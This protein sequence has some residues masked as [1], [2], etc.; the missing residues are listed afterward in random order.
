MAQDVVIETLDTL[1]ALLQK[2]GGVLLPAHRGEAERIV[3]AAWG[4]ERAYIGKL[5]ESGQA[6]ISARD[7]A[8][9]RDF[10]RGTHVEL[11]TRRYGLSKRRIWAILQPERESAAP[12]E[13]TAQAI[14]AAPTAAACL[15]G[16]S[17]GG[18]AAHQRPPARANTTK[19]RAPTT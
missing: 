18:D 15:T 12:A 10:Q 19:A 6:E 3:R 1:I 7:R 14:L 17:A 8:I 5:G 2:N 11:L 9:R 13:Q 16:G 4:G